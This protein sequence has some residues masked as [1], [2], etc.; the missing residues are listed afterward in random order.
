MTTAFIL[1]FTFRWIKGAKT[2]ITAVFILMWL[3]TGVGAYFM[4]TYH[5]TGELSTKVVAA[6]APS[7]ADHLDDHLFEPVWSG[8][9]VVYRPPPGCLDLCTSDRVCASGTQKSH[10]SNR[11]G[12]ITWTI[13]LQNTPIDNHHCI[14]LLLFTFYLILFSFFGQFRCYS[15][16]SKSALNR[17]LP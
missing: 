16:D 12:N 6:S 4:C 8:A 14:S 9:Q 3:V 2:Y 7:R 10:R 11:F 5:V 15:L 13:Q 17:H 1:P